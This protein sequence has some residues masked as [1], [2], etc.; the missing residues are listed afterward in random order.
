MNVFDGANKTPTRIDLSGDSFSPG[1]GALVG[2]PN[3]E[4]AMIH[5]K[6]N[7]LV[8]AD[9]IRT[10]MANETITLMGNQTASIMGNQTFTLMG[11][12]TGTINGNCTKTIMGMLNETLIAGQNTV[13]VGPYNR[14][15]VAPCTWLCPS[16]SQLNSGNWFEF[17]M[18]KVGIYPLRMTNLGLDTTIRQT[19]VDL[20]I[21]KVKTDSICTKIRNLEN[22]AVAGLKNKTIT[23]LAAVELARSHINGLHSEARMIRPAVGIEIS[24]PPSSL[25]GVQ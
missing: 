24:A 19:N 5:G 1:M 14:T 4:D 15:D 18:L 22:A 8:E 6:L 23:V 2:S 10:F 17:K 21:N 13:C 12:Y 7:Q 16:S 9:I 3:T 25:P 11:N 20:T